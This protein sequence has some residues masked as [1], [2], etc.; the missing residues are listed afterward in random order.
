V[1]NKHGW[2]I[3]TTDTSDQ[4]SRRG[5]TTSIYCMQQMWTVGCVQRQYSYTVDQ[6]TKHLPND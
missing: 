5:N 6:K 1:I 4:R 3:A 2:H